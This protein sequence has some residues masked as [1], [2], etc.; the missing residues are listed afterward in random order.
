MYNITDVDGIIIKKTDS[1]IAAKI[2][3]TELYPHC[4]FDGDPNFGATRIYIYDTNDN[5]IGYIEIPQKEL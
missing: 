3:A 1:L 5:V 2:F 4:F